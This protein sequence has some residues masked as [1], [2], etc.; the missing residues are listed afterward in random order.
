MQQNDPKVA[1]MI[2]D[3]VPNQSITNELLFLLLSSQTIFTIIKK[4]YVV[5][6]L[7]FCFMEGNEKK[8][9]YHIDT[10]FFLL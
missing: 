6:N 8:K 9:Y 1:S 5:P 4:K 7:Y 2:Y 10:A 3:A